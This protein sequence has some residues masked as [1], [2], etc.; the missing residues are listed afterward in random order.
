MGAALREALTATTRPFNGMRQRTANSSIG[1]E[2][3]TE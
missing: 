1:F 2:P 3:L